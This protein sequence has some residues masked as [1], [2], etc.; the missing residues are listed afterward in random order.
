MAG[1]R[2]ILS[3]AHSL[4]PPMTRIERRS[5]GE[6]DGLTDHAHR[7][8]RAAPLTVDTRTTLLD[9]LRDRL[10]DHVAEEGLRPR[11]VRRLHGAA[12][13]PPRAR[14]AW[15]SR[16]PTTAPSVTTADGLGAGDRPAPGAAGVPRP[17]RLPVRLLHAGPDLLGGRH[18]RGGR[19]PATRATSPQDLD[20]AGR[21]DRRGDPRADERQP[22]PLR[23]LRRTS[24][25][26]IREAA[27]LDE[28]VRLRAGRPT[29]PSAV[30]ARRRR[31][32]GAA[33]LARRHQPRRPPQARRRHARTCSST[34]AGCR[35][36]ASRSA[37]TAAC[38][39]APASATATSPP[40]ARPR[41]LP[42]AR[43]GAAGRRVGPAAQPGHDRRQPAAAHPLRLLPGRHHAVQQARAGHGLLGDRRATR[44]TTRSSAPPSTASPSTPRT[45][46]S[47]WRRSTPSVVVLGP[48]GERTRAR[49]PSCTGC[50]AT[51]PQRDTVLEHGE[52]ITAV[53]LPPLPSRARSAYRKVRDR[54]SYAFALV[55][56]AAVARRRRTARSRD[57]RLALGGVAHKP[58]RAPPRRGRR[59]AGRRPTEERSARPPRPSSPPR[60]AARRDNA[61]QGADGRATRMIAVLRDLAAEGA[62]MTDRR[63]HRAPIGTPLDRASTAR[64]RSRGTGALRLRAAGRRP[65]RTCTPCRRPSPA[66]GSPRSTPRRPR[67]STACSP[68]SPTA[69]APRLGVRPTTGAARSC[70]RDDVALPRPARRRRGRRDRRRSRAQAADLVR[71]RVR[72]AAARRRAARRPR[73][74]LRAREV[75]PDYPTDTDEGDVDAALAAAAGHGRPDLHDADVAQQPDGAARHASRCGTDG[76][77]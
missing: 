71:V 47:R 68:C 51:T 73:R 30:A 64:P 74:P 26:A 25:P 42:G 55:S 11:P 46:R 1:T 14:P 35:S 43:A 29:P 67:R 53:E 33:F 27:A 60:A 3:A 63:W 24:S 76:R 49:S 59:C 66:A 75:N 20:R 40:T 23:R 39:S 36:T 18:A 44:A 32:P 9:A 54:A 45:W 16:S 28:A 56:V 77:G 17:R 70:S 6:I 5:S 7:R 41:A 34:S 37:A 62:P 15:R 2:R 61:L 48:D 19:A 38:G 58:W 8:R 21:A 22:V 12:R 4:L 69:N 50:P 57:V 31:S 10:G 52:L 72:R 65:R 13:R